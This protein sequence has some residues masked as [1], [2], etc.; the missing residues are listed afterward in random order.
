MR[1]WQLTLETPTLPSKLSWLRAGEDRWLS[2][3]RSLAMS[4]CTL[5]P[6]FR[7]TWDTGLFAIKKVQQERVAI[8]NAGAGSRGGIFQN[9][10]SRQ[11][12]TG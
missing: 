5:L 4:S 1:R 8:D 6:A 10:L 3:V 11:A 12:T 9:T 2:F 7:R